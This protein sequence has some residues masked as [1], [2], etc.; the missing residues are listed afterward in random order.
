MKDNKN[1][2]N[3]ATG[4]STRKIFFSGDKHF[5]HK[6][7]IKICNRPYKDV[8]EMAEDYLSK[9]NSVVKNSDDY[10]DLGDIG[11]R[12]SPQYIASLIRRMNGRI[13]IILG[14]H[15][16]PLR[17]A[18]RNGLLKDLLDSGKLEIYGSIDPNTITAKIIHIEGKRVVLSHYAYRT[19]PSAFRGTIHLYGHSHGNLNDFYRSFDVGVDSNNG[20]PWEWSEVINKTMSVSTDEFKEDKVK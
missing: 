20:Y 7:V 4:T 9:H 15:D 18:I 5:G 3:T 12:C 1:T 2:S 10:H 14:N 6:S 19:W 8:Y 16:K 11:Y 17:A 13:H